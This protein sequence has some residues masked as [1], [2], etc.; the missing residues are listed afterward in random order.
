MTEFTDYAPVNRTL[1][2][3]ETNEPG[4]YS[5]DRENLGDAPGDPYAVEED[6]YTK[7]ALRQWKIC[8][9]EVAAL[10]FSVKNIKRIQK[11]I[12]REIYNRSYGKFRL[13]EDQNVLDLLVAMVIVFEWYGKSLPTQVVRQV[14]VLNAETVQYVAPDMMTNFVQ[15]YGYLYDIKNP[16]NPIPPPIN[17]NNAGRLQLPSVAQLYGI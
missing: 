17:V 15:H 1:T 2:Y 3:N 14:K 10:Y 11:L 7:L 13:N 16:V 8:P 6:Y 9:S 12:R 5:M 4:R